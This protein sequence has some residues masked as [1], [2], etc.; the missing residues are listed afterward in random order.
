MLQPLWTS[1]LPLQRA[2]LVC[3]QGSG[4]TFNAVH[5]AAGFPFPGSC[6]KS[7]KAQDSCNLYWISPE[8]FLQKCT[9]FKN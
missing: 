2:G 1:N 4:N 6:A 5:P 8:S 7:L 3:T 9:A